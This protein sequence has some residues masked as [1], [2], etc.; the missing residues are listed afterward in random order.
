MSAER[1]TMDPAEIA[2]QLPTARDMRASRFAD[3]N[4]EYFN[5]DQK[6]IQGLKNASRLA[7][8]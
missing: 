4:S 7:P 2:A 6:G 5:N 1:R 3:P 8:L